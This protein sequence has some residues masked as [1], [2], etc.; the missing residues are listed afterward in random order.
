MSSLVRFLNQKTAWLCETSSR[1]GSFIASR[2]L[3]ITR[4]TTRRYSEVLSFTV[5]SI[6]I[7]QPS[8]EMR[9]YLTLWSGMCLIHDSTPTVDFEQFWIKC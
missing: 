5:S 7:L 6:L 3:A 4:L 9:L 1:R 8:D 2:K